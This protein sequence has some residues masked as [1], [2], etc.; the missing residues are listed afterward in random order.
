MRYQ[1]GARR[2]VRRILLGG[3]VPPLSSANLPFNYTQDQSLEIDS[4]L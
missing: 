2:T 1:P 3:C 4:K